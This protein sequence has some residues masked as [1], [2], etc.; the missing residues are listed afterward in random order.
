MTCDN[1]NIEIDEAIIVNGYNSCGDCKELYDKVV[2]SPIFT[3]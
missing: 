1:C 3:E 2:S